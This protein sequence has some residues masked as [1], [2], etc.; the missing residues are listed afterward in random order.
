MLILI[1]VILAI[2]IIW[3]IVLLPI[4]TMVHLSFAGVNRLSIKVTLLKMTLYKNV[5]YLEEKPAD[6][7]SVDDS[8]ELFMLDHQKILPGLRAFLQQM[9]S[10]KNG[11]LLI[12]E[13]IVVHKIKWVTHFGT[14]EASSTG[15]LAGS[16]WGVKGA[17]K[18]LI[19]KFGNISCDPTMTVVPH[20][21]QKYF[22]T[23]FQCMVSIRFAKAISVF[24][25]LFF[26]NRDIKGHE[27]R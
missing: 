18:G 7:T 2:L 1:F 8:L 13:N 17:A 22:K 11:L 4:K 23:D 12:L 6:D 9:G 26:Q 10:F 25:K 24:I 15:M 21:Q 19:Y 3:L 5:W 20:F 16:I 14:G 27:K